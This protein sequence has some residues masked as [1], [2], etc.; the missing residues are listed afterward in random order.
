MFSTSVNACQFWYMCKDMRQL[1]Q[2][3]VD[4]QPAKEGYLTWY[5]S[6]QSATV[7]LPFCAGAPAGCNGPEPSSENEVRPPD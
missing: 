2:Y 4:H 7:L 6:L 1:L 5:K 3:N